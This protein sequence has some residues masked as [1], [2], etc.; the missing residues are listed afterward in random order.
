MNF[1]WAASEADSIEDVCRLSVSVVTSSCS[2][3]VF[4]ISCHR[5]LFSMAERVA[6]SMRRVDSNMDLID[7]F[8]SVNARIDEDAVSS[9]DIC[10]R[11]EEIAA[12][13]DASGAARS[14]RALRTAS[15]A[16]QAVNDRNTES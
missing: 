2:A 11:D 15:I 6:E 9:F 13:D 4:V 3:I 16:V 7:A 1:D 5:W 14:A 12:I 8:A 10:L